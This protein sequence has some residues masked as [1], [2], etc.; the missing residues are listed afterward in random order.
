METPS[1]AVAQ[2]KELSV[3]RTP[4]PITQWYEKREDAARVLEALR[5]KAKDI[6]I[7]RYEPE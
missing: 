1:W 2:Y 4:T 5:N 6:C 3:G 7:V